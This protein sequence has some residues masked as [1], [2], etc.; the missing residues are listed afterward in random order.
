MADARIAA[1][2]LQQPIMAGERG[3]PQAQHRLAAA[4]RQ[5]Q[6]AL[7]LLEPGRQATH[8]REN[9]G[10]FRSNRLQRLHIALPSGDR[11]VAQLRRHIAAAPTRTCHVPVGG[12]AARQKGALEIH[13]Q[14]LA[15]QI[16]RVTDE[17]LAGL[18]LACSEP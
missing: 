17:R 16:L 4:L 13:A 12:G 15:R 8:L 10:E 7:R 18:A 5:V 11:P 2:L 3:Q 1:S 14:P 9:A 6:Q